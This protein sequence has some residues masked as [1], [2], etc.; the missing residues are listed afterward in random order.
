MS[1]L[2]SLALSVAIAPL[3]LPA[4]A[5]SAQETG[6]VVSLRFAWPAGIAAEVE[7][8]WIRHS[9]PPA[10]TV[11]VRSRSRMETVAD[12]R[13]I[14]VRQE[15]VGEPEVVEP[16]ADAGEGRLVAALAARLAAVRPSFV[17][18]TEGEFVELVEV[19]RLQTSVEALLQS[20]M[21]RVEGATA[22]VIALLRTLVSVE[23]LSA[24]AE[25]EWGMLVAAWIGAE[26]EVGAFY[27]A[28]AEEPHPL[29]PS[30]TIPAAVEFA[31]AGRVP[32]TDA[33]TAPRCVQLAMESETD[34]AAL[35]EAVIAVLRQA[36]PDEAEAFARGLQGMSMTESLTVVAEPGTLL[37]HRMETVKVTRVA[38]DDAGPTAGLARTQE[39]RRVV[40]FRYE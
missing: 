25:Q 1:L 37:P 17:V 35:R 2:R 31:V 7:Q 33:E 21:E 36:S 6:E 38:A 18:S 12:P 10:A 23:A 15:T 11:H 19:E 5:A 16:A 39:D 24:G 14:V 26:L 3:L 29:V 4:A 30:V 13:G 9:G 32:C 22:D 28:E 20:A 27:E 40:R 34:P 8:E